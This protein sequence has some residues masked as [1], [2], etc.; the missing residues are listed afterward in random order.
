MRGDNEGWEVVWKWRM[1]WRRKHGV[2]R[3]IRQRRPPDERRSVP[4]RLVMRQISWPGLPDMTD[5][6][7]TTLIT[8]YPRPSRRPRIVLTMPVW[9]ETN[10]T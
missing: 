6:A 10:L 1:R 5:P 7:S 2:Y 8:R 3:Y 9:K 4:P